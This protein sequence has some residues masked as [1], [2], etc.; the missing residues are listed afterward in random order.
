MYKGEKPEVKVGKHTTPEVEKHVTPEVGKHTV[1]EVGEHVVPEVEPVKLGTPS[2][3]KPIVTPEIKK[4]EPTKLGTLGKFKLPI[5]TISKKTV[6]GIVYNDVHL[7]NGEEMILSDKD[8]E[9]QRN[10]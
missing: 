4:T 9:A 6:N 1:P 3:T 8:L 10:S 2:I 5:H 7:V